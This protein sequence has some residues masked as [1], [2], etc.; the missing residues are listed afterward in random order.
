MERK[1]VTLLAGE[2]PD[3]LHEA[4]SQA[5]FRRSQDLAYRPACDGCSAC[6]AVRIPAR[7][8]SPNRTQKRTLAR[9]GD[10]TALEI[11]GQAR[12]EHFHLF[13]RY[14]AERHADGGMADM[15]YSD[16]RAMVEDSPVKTHLV[17]FREAD[18]RLAAVCLTDKMRDGLSLVYS[19]FDPDLY[20]RSLGQYMILWH[21]DRAIKRGLDYVYLGYWISESQKMAYKANFQPLEVLTS[22][23]WRPFGET[24]SPDGSPRHVQQDNLDSVFA[25][26][27]NAAVQP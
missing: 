26:E 27:T 18:G 14:L 6:K 4:L 20:Q 16:Y 2:D 9:N 10:L 25:I 22:R 15:D 17:E 21:V 19:F 8:F 23:G 11:G 7:M 1:V 24:I 12:P 13:H 3:Q 5:G